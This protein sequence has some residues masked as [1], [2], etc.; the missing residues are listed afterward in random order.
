MSDEDF[1]GSSQ[2]DMRSKTN[3][4]KFWSKTQ[5][6]KSDVEY[7]WIILFH[8]DIGNQYP[9]TLHIRTLFSTEEIPDT[10]YLFKLR[11]DLR[12]KK[13]YFRVLN[14]DYSVFCK[15]EKGKKIMFILS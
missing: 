9:F 11:D 5:P 6:Q 1:F 13:Q 15:V 7:F 10:W 4:P 8:H 3:V 12:F 14:G 2:K